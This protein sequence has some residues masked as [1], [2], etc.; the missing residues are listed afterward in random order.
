MLSM[1]PATTTSAERARR[2]SLATIAA[3]MPE[4]HILLMVVAPA[5]SG[6]PA[7]IAAWRA[8]AW[9]RPAGST[10]PIRISS[11]LVAAIPARSTAAA[12]ARAPSAGAL[13]S[14]RSPRKP[15]IGVR[16]APTLQYLAGAGVGTLG[17]VDDDEVALS[18]LHRQIIHGTGDIGR[19]KTE[20]A[21]AA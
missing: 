15:P 13:T 1:P 3:F 10:Q 5:E 7:P 17:I 2:R 8:G 18:N 14:F 4:P 16:A 11:T 6:N 9:P 19:P 20:S 21:A 12:I